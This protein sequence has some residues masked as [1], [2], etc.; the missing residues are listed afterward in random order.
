MAT[1][2]VSSVAV[3]CAAVTYSVGGTV[4]GVAGVAPGNGEI[5]DNSFVLQNVL[6]NTLIIPRNG[7]F[8]FATPEA[9]NDQFE[10][11]VFHGPSTQNQF[12]TLHDYKGVVTTNIT[13]IIVDCGH[14]DWTWIDGTNTAGTVIPVRLNTANFLRPRR[15]LFR[16]HL[17][18]PRERVTV[19][20]VGQISSGACISSA[21]TVGN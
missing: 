9:L 16:I 20:Q 4:V 2:N 14:N 5:A 10:I 12:C 15:P 7:P 1:A 18:T 21:A 6:G 3:T 13:S 19:Q 11:S 17:P 8:T